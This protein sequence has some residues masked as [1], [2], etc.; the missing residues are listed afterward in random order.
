MNKATITDAKMGG[1]GPLVQQDEGEGLTYLDPLQPLTKEYNYNVKAGAYRITERLRINELYGQ[2]EKFERDLMASV[3]D[4]QETQAWSLLNGGFSTGNTGFDGLAL[5]STSHTRLDGGTNQSNRPSADT[6]LS[7]AALADAGIQFE[8]WV[9]ERGRPFIS[10]PRLLIIPPDLKYVARELLQSEKKPGS[11]DND[12]NAIREDGLSY[13]VCH[14]LTST[15]AWFLLGDSHDLNW[16]WRFRPQSGAE[17]DFDTE[18]IKRKVRQA[19]AYGFG[20]WRG[21][22]GSAG[23]G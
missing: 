6:A 5:F 22:Y 2:V 4:D 20:E 19:Y 8:N 9:N 17:T 12:I 7:L 18:D 16:L 1:F 21:T 15:T 11:A 13:K 23:T 14:H 10:I 3:L